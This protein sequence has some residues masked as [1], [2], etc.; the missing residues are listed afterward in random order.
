M[1]NLFDAERAE[2]RPSVRAV[3]VDRQQGVNAG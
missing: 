1:R 2:A 3:T